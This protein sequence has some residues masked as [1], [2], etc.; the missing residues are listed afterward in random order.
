MV[1]LFTLVK[2]HTQENIF[3][4]DHLK[5]MMIMMKKLSYCRS[6]FYVL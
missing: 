2:N 6:V 1:V 4:V 3:E 5:K